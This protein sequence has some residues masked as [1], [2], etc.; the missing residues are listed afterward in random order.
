KKLIGKRVRVVIDYTKP[1]SDGYEER[2]CAT[3]RAGGGPEGGENVALPLQLP[4]LPLNCCVLSVSKQSRDDDDRSSDYDRLQ[5]AELEAQKE[6]RGAH[7]QKEPPAWAEP[8]DASESSA[9]AKQL[10]SFLQRAGRISA[11]VD[12][13]ASGSRFR[14]F[15]PRESCKLTM[16]LAGV[17]TPKAARNPNEQSEPF[18]DE[19]LEYT[20]RKALQRDVGGRFTTGEGCCRSSV[21]LNAVV[22]LARA[23]RNRG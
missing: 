14:M 21:I 15:V 12:Y 22:A 10:L 11:V 18:G 13:V 1:A 16:V 23:G 8:R 19:A 20:S 9:K 5:V 2:D 7:S 17:R 4:L 6:G 3:I